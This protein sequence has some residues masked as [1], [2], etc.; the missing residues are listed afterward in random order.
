M[1]ARLQQGFL[2]SKTS[3]AI[4]LPSNH[5]SIVSILL[6]SFLE[7][8]RKAKSQP[9]PLNALPTVLCLALNFCLST[10]NEGDMMS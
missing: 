2:E 5:E 7:P 6:W 8:W 4:S 10:E 3:A 1:Q 9:F